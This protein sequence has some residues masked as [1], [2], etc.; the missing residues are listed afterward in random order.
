M[1]QTPWKRKLGTKLRRTETEPEIWTV[2][3]NCQ[4]ST[5]TDQK[6]SR[7]H[8]LR[9]KG[10]G[11]RRHIQRKFYRHN[12][13]AQNFLSDYDRFKDETYAYLHSY[14]TQ[15]NPRKRNRRNES[16]TR[17]WSRRTFHGQELRRRTR[18]RPSETPE[19]DYS[20]QR[21]RNSEPRRGDNPFYMDP[22]E[23]RQENTFRKTL[24][25][26]LGV[27]GCNFWIPMVQGE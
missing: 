26:R 23:D 17:Y 7:R 12:E 10:R 1:V 14:H 6:H 27:Y 8:G 15:D 16:P 20:Q 24:D 3:E 18:Y 11:I 9:R 22:S 2:Q 25:H 19:P 4:N 21:R 5:G 13:H